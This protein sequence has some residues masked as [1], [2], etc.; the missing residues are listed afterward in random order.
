MVATMLAPGLI[1]GSVLR[2][3]VL[4]EADLPQFKA[5]D[6]QRVETFA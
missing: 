4:S 3:Y 6:P 5:G 1:E 2:I